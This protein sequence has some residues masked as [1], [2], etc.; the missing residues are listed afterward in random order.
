V[1]SRLISGLLEGLVPQGSSF[2]KPAWR[3]CSSRIF[4]EGKRWSSKSP[5][6]GAA[7]GQLMSDVCRRRRNGPGRRLD[8]KGLAV[9][10]AALST[11]FRRGLKG[12]LGAA[13]EGH[14][15]L[16]ASEAV[17]ERIRSRETDLPP[18]A[19]PL[20]QRAEGFLAAARASALA[21]RWRAAVT[22]GRIAEEEFRAILRVYGG[23]AIPPRRV[24][25]HPR[26][27][28]SVVRILPEG[29]L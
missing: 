9:T 16:E 21:G 23:F 1:F 7:P 15:A 12:W 6:T 11:L 10:S 25:K 22:F 27:G 13:P 20:L 3:G 24:S 4:G 19:I 8:E 17:A 18:E 28:I 5:R 26:N 29:P 14:A 2:I